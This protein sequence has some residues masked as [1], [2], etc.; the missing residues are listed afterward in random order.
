MADQQSTPER[1]AVEAARKQLR[2]QARAKRL[3]ATLS[4]LVEKLKGHPK[5]LIVIALALLAGVA[6]DLL[7]GGDASFFLGLLD[8]ITLSE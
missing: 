2:Q 7:R 1:S 5:A 3:R 8:Q 6:A 4:L